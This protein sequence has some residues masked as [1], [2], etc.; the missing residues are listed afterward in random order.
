MSGHCKV[1]KPPLLLQ[2]LSYLTGE[3]NYGG[4]VTDAHDRRTL[5]SILSIFYTPQI[6]EPNYRFSPSGLYCPP[7]N[8]DYQG[9]LDA[10]K[11]LP[12]AAEPEVFGLHANA[13]ITK[14]QQEADLVLS[15]CL[16]MQGAQQQRRLC[17]EK[18]L[19]EAASQAGQVVLR[20]LHG[21]C[22]EVHVY[23]R[24]VGLGCPPAEFEHG[25][26][27]ATSSCLF[28]SCWGSDA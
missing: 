28:R 19:L 17:C 4:R 1:M 5:S 24:W 12:S 21:L 20:H 26:G 16:A 22:A 15:S 27:P 8:T 18:R 10:I 23:V 14:D 9:Y 2:A 3:C 13:D 7:P 6:F 25:A 11:Q